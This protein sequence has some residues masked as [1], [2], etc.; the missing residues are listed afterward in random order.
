MQILEFF[1]GTFA[2]LF[3]N[4]FAVI[5]ACGRPGSYREL[6]PSPVIGACALSIAVTT[7]YR[8]GVPPYATTLSL[9][10]ISVAV[11]GAYIFRNRGTFSVT[12]VFTSTVAERYLCVIVIAVLI[13]LPHY[14]GGEQFA[15]FQGNRHDA[16]N[17]LSGAFGF[18]NY[19]Y[20]YLSNF[21]V[22][23]EPAAG[24]AEAARM[25][26]QRPAVALLYASFYKLFSRGF[27]SNA[28]EYCLV[29][30][31]NFYFAFLYLSVSVFSGRERLAQLV[32]AAFCVGFFGQY[33]LDINAWG[34]LFA[35]P[36]MVVLVTD[37]CR[38]LLILSQSPNDERREL[39]QSSERAG[40]VPV[41]QRA[42][43]MFLFVRLPIV[44]AGMIY[45]YPEIAPVAGLGCAAALIFRILEDVTRGRYRIVLQTLAANALFA[46]LA[47][48][49]VSGYWKGTLGFL[50]QQLEMASQA[51][52]NWHY[53]FQ[54]YLFG[55]GAEVAERIKSSVQLDYLFYV[56]LAAPANFLA[57]IF[58]L[59]FLQLQGV[60]TRA[61]DPLYFLWAIAL[62]VWFG[63]VILGVASSARAEFRSRKGA[64][65]N[66][67][68]CLV[69]VAALATSIVPI[70]LL[71]KGQYWAAGKGLSMISPFI[72]LGLIMPVMARHTHRAVFVLVSLVIAGHVLFGA[73]R[74]IILAYRAD[75]THF[76]YPYPSILAVYKTGV[77]WDISRY[78]KD[79]GKCALV[80]VDIHEPFLERVVENY[81]MEK[82]V[83]W[84]SPNPQKAYYG[85]KADLPR[86]NAPDGQQQDCTV[87]TDAGFHSNSANVIVLNPRLTPRKEHI[88]HAGQ[89]L[90]V[91]SGLELILGE[92]WSQ[93]ESWGVWSDGVRAQLLLQMKPEDFSTGVRIQFSFN[94]Y[95]SKTR[96]QRLEISLAGRK[97]ASRTFNESQPQQ[98][99]EINLDASSINLFAATRVDLSIPDAIAPAESGGADKRQL[100]VGLTNVRVVKQ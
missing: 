62:L 1:V 55:G 27:L 18:A 12:G 97:L 66:S 46:F 8:W 82:K 31:L 93:P 24:L 74:P 15:I 28:Y 41:D 61:P 3:V 33:I 53:F 5:V 23:A 17:Y 21:D 67:L 92:G 64:S 40:P 9:T 99:V 59:Y 35:V 70:G 36:M 100:G 6:L 32:S 22:A 80:M 26:G 72:F 75:G 60:W 90:G 50:L 13:L 81:L 57:G 98:L 65:G 20:S 44:A 42:T 39:L 87:T 86:R 71:A 16:V 52:V 78:E 2:L 58:G 4:G 76:P 48:I 77:E 89:S 96:E 49:L 88:L 85:E 37:Y 51:S 29:G 34:E 11:A 73:F 56:F 30:Q 84:F 14:L 63:A 54:A 95:V 43:L 45:V 38:A 91:G 19:S 94:S 7:L 47:L 83:P 25:L 10:A 68:L 79:I 69:A